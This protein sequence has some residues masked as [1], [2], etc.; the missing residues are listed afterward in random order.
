MNESRDI[1]NNF[2]SDLI[3]NV[4]NNFFENLLPDEDVLESQCKRHQ[5]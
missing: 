4:L 1:I 5:I 3:I 2:S